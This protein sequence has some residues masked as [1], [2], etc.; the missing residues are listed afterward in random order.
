MIAPQG[1]PLPDAV[2]GMTGGTSLVGGGMG[3]PSGAMSVG[4]LPPLNLDMGPS[5]P[6]AT[7]GNTETGAQNTTTGNGALVFKGAEAGSLL[8]TVQGVL[9]LVV[10]G[11]LAIFAM[12]QL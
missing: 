6:I 1:M 8:A 9:P 5:M 7:I 12:R 2:A 3:V 11:G 10:I 4:S